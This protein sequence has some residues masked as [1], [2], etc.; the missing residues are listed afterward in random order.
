MRLHNLCFALAWWAA[1]LSVIFIHNDA[2][3]TASIIAA[4]A[5][6]AVTAVL[7][8]RAFKRGDV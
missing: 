1:F 7:Y 8:H 3:W 6:S 5:L 4:V 2:A